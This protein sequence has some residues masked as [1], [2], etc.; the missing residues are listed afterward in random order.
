MQYAMD[1]LKNK[2]LPLWLPITRILEGGENEVFL[3]YLAGEKRPFESGANRR[4]SVQK[5]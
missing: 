5:K 1:Y 4:A 2:G 3:T